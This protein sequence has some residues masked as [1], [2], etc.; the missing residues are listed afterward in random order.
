[1]K[2][3][4]F[5]ELI[6][7]KFDQ[8]EFE[9]NPANWDRLDDRMDKKATRRKILMWLP[10]API[11][12]IS[13]I[14][15]SLAM[16]ITIPVLMNHSN[17]TTHV[18]QHSAVAVHN[19]IDNTKDQLENTN[20]T[21]PDA[22][23]NDV[24]ITNK[25]TKNIIISQPEKPGKFILTANTAAIVADLF[26]N[27]EN[28]KHGDANADHNL[29]R[30]FNENEF[31]YG[32]GKYRSRLSGIS[33]ISIIGGFN[34]GANTNVYSVGANAK[35]ML[36]DKLYVESD[37]A[38]VDNTGIE[39]K[40]DPS[41]YKT[42]Y[43]MAYPVQ[44]TDNNMNAPTAM[45]NTP[46]TQGAP[47]VQGNAFNNSGNP[48]TTVSKTILSTARI[49][50]DPGPSVPTGTAPALPDIHRVKY[51]LYYG[52]ITPG[53]G[54]HIHKNL[55]IGVGADVQRLLQGESSISTSTNATTASDVAADN[56]MV[57]TFDFGLVGKT[58]VTV[59]DRIKASVYYRQGMN[60][61][62]NPG[63]KYIDRSYMQVHLRYTIFRK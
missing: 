47:N 26:N 52:Q 46:M 13:S 50:S 22:T 44:T 1:M 35:K 3:N 23:I 60:N 57:P 8:N 17:N 62:V 2:P 53:V 40:L 12:Y 30:S 27:K 10:L 33:S 38:F 55:A 5:D 39:N 19:N 18:A 51:D 28:N 15:A 59:T 54:Y 9:Y 7:R 24:V 43:A 61:V 14:A 20:T 37:I 16:I 34:Y 25:N 36:N 45:N 63:N 49:A 6:R 56:K 21:P 32:P 31:V 41:A 48:G 29:P 58:E 4:E 42:S 11:A